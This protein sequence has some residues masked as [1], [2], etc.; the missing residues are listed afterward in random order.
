MKAMKT[1]KF[2]EDDNIKAKL[3]SPLSFFYKKATENRVAQPGYKSTL[4][5]ICVGN[6]TA[7]GAGKTPVAIALGKLLKNMGKQPNYVTKGHGR[8]SAESLKVE[9]QAASIVG[10]EPLLLAKIAPT[11]VATSRVD[12]AKLAE[13]NKADAIILDDGFQDP[14]LEKNLSFLVIDGAYGLGNNKVIPAGPLR[15]PF[16]EAVKRADAV[17]IIG[18][19]KK[20]LPQL[21]KPVL[22]AS[23]KIEVPELLK[24]EDIVAFCGIGIPQKFYDSLKVAG[25]NLVGEV[26]YPD[27]H[28][29]T[30]QD[31]K[32]V[33]ARATEK[34]AMVVTTEKDYVKVPENLKMLIRVIKSELVFEDENAVKELLKK[35][36]G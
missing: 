22:K 19:Q 29:Y 26:S 4:P 14:S 35:C 17:I 10:D 34:Q 5:V 24:E 33:F 25:L 9:G 7:G 23:L 8:E 16:E 12:G 1:P 36:V 30:E 3:L 31:F 15:E 13:V 27:H 2:W 21:G 20:T 11:Y 6:I 32:D 28:P 18:E